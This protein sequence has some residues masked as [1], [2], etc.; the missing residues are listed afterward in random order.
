MP[1]STPLWWTGTIHWKWITACHL[2]NAAALEKLLEVA[3]VH[4]LSYAET[5]WRECKVQAAGEKAAARPLEKGLQHQLLLW[6]D[7]QGWQSQLVQVAGGHSHHGW[8]QWDHPGLPKGRPHVLCHCLQAWEAWQPACGSHLWW[9]CPGCG[10]LLGAVDLFGKGG[11]G[12]EK[13]LEKGS[14]VAVT[15][16]AFGKG[17][18]PWSTKTFGKRS[19]QKKGFWKRADK[20][21]EKGSK[22][23]ATSLWE[24]AHKFHHKS[25]WKRAHKFHPKSLWKRAH[26]KSLWKRAHVSPKLCTATPG[27]PVAWCDY[28]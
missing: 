8:L 24:R 11:A 28:K 6:E 16:N 26:K 18:K 1:R 12:N 14:Q 23:S 7:W 21:L 4:I 25:L 20:P 3:D 2:R 15:P 19:N 13:P 22:V 17:P 27:P 10:L 5:K 9:L